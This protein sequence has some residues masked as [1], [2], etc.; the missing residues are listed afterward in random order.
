MPAE[1]PVITRFAP[2]PTGHLHVG[3]ARTALFCWA[4]ARRHGGRF[5]LR[6]EDTDQKRSSE[7]AARGI[8]EDLA[9]LGI[10][11]DEGPIWA[12]PRS[13]ADSGL[14]TFGGDPRHVG[15]FFQ[16]QRLDIYNRHLDALIERDLAYPSFDT[17]EELDALRREAAAR[18]E[19]FRYRR[20]PGYDHAAALRRYRAGEPCVV[21]FRMPEESVRV[22]DA[23][24]GEIDFTEEHLDDFVLRKAD[25]FPTYHFAVVVDDELMGVTHVLRGQEHL[26][27]TPRH[28]SLQHALGFRT[29]VYAHM[30]LIFNPD[31]SK[32]SKRDKD[33]TV[34]KAMLDRAPSGSGGAGVSPA[35][36]TSLLSPADLAQWLSDKTRQLPTDALLALARELDLSLPEIDV[37]DFRRSGYLPETLCNYLALLGWNPGLKN[38]DGTDLE[39]FDMAF[40]AEH[41]SLD[42]IGKSNAKFDRDKLL[43]F[44]QTMIASLEPVE[45]DRRW[46]EWCERY[47]PALP[48]LLGDRFALASRAVQPR[49][50]T[51]GQCREPIAFALIPD[52]GVRYDEKAVEKNLRKGNP[53]GLD[54]LRD[55]LPALES[56]PRFT[57]DAIDA[58]AKAFCESR[59]LGMGRL[60]QPLRIA[61]TGSTVS[62]GL[63]ETLSL[64]GRE[65]TVR[66]IC[67]CLETV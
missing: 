3:G 12:P 24:L 62:P 60:A 11:W 65:G 57:P 50:R 8:L 28:V 14:S 23:V 47:D 20:R 49:I 6:I 37:E 39:R 10:H 16:A 42:R 26:N 13:V 32:M 40:L 1:N 21:R 17:A 44:N 33:K 61:V 25:G 7:D 18:K 5:I 9:W 56:L 41:F 43:A 46:R 27:N 63:G 2:S 4:Y 36:A 55:F 51:F 35:S 31:G 67:R 58:A 59:S 38:P 66:R 45:F 52:D 22:T 48:S 15:P 30:P 19:T 54:V 29:P 34:R 53:R 64:V